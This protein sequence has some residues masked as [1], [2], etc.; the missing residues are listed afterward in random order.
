[1]IMITAPGLICSSV[2]T[3]P[4]GSTSIPSAK[5]RAQICERAP[6]HGTQEASGY[7]ASG[8]STVASLVLPGSCAGLLLLG[9]PGLGYVRLLVPTGPAW[10][11]G[12]EL[13]LFYCP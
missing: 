13:S 5:G 2:P 11:W 12:K 10:Q 1:M 4:T 9:M 6:A 3:S 7:F 8:H